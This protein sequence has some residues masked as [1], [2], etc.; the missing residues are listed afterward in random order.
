LELKKQV[1][2]GAGLWHM[3]STQRRDTLG[4]GRKEDSDCLS[5]EGRHID[6]TPI[7]GAN[8]VKVA[9]K[10]RTLRRDRELNWRSPTA[11]YAA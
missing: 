7:P 1:G 5:H 9:M 4:G 3:T 10:S 2:A 11:M 8:Q 6:K